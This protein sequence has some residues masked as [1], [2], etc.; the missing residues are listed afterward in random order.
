[1]KIALKLTGVLMIG[2]ALVLGAALAAQVRREAWLFEDDMRRDDALMG[3]WLAAAALRITRSDGPG[4]AERFIADA[5]GASAHVKIRRVTAA[6]VNSAEGE[7]RAH[8]SSALSGKEQTWIDRTEGSSGVLHMLIPVR[9]GPTSAAGDVLE[10]TES[11]AAERAYVRTTMVRHALT[12]GTIAL[13]CAGVALGLGVLVVGAPV[14]QM[15]AQARRVGRGDLSGRL[16]ARGSDELGELETEINSMCDQLAEARE[17]LDSETAEKIRTLEQLRRADRLATVGTLASGV[18]HELGTPLNVISARAKM[19]AAGEVQGHESEESARIMVEQTDRIS[20]II[21]QL[22]DFARPRRPA[23]EPLDLRQLARQSV[24]LLA[25]M[26]AARGVKVELEDGAEPVAALA[27]GSQMQQVLSNLI[28]NALQASTRGG[29]VLV[30]VGVERARPP[31]DVAG[32]EGPRACVRV[33]DQGQGI[34]PENLV[35]LFEPFFTTKEV[36]EGTGLGLSVSNGIVREHGGWIDVTSTP[37]RGA[38]F[39]VCLPVGER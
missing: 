2:I 32:T 18:A 23:R 30:S 39:C 27:D 20:R 13:V 21:R 16:P 10:L 31:A 1:M 33:R 34:S 25:P 38:C 4:A 8:L 12:A 24:L 36:G 17:R 11:L 14:K 29:R 5:N 35:H 7:R 3:H 6:E 28:V 26:A 15:I 37:G 9:D 22:L 19:I